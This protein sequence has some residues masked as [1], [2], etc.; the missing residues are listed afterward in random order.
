MIQF[1]TAILTFFIFIC[2]CFLFLSCDTETNTQKT[3]Q[4]VVSGQVPVLKKQPA[5]DAPKEIITEKPEVVSP[6]E[7][8]ARQ[9]E[10]QK[11]IAEEKYNSTGKIDPFIP[12]VGGTDQSETKEPEKP[13]RILTP[14]EKM[15]L[16]QIRLVAVMS[17]GDKR[18]AMVEEASGKGYIVNVGT[19][20]GRNSGTIDRIENDRIIIKETTKNF[21]GELKEQYHEMKLH[22]QENEE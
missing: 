2:F 8:A 13:A 3:K 12:L 20:I 21:K 5:P 14:L 6:E 16:G 22:K 7:A 1:K 10:I 15:D 17:S 4:L 9:E 18:T 11:Q 19:Y